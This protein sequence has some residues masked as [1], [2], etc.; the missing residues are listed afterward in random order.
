MAD[1]SDHSIAKEPDLDWS[2]VRETVAMLNLAAARIEYSMRDG[3]DS[4]ET[5]T[6]SF[7][8][9]VGNIQIINMACNDLEDSETK[10]IISTNCDQVSQKVQSVI[11]AFQFYDRMSQRINHISN[12]LTSLADIV[13]E[14]KRLY[15]PYEWKGLQEMIKSKYTLDSDI[16]MFDAIIAGKDVKAVLADAI[17]EKKN[18]PDSDIELF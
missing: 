4:V 18:K 15:S 12:I 3:D 14:P 5:L 6:E 13:S 2:Q 1:K 9:M 11:V 7:T 16:K 17:E 10:A 8:E